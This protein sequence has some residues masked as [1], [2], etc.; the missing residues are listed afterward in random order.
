MIEEET[1]FDPLVDQEGKPVLDEDGAQKTR[2]RVVR[3]F[4]PTGQ[5]AVPQGGDV[6]STGWM[7]TMTKFLG[8]KMMVQAVNPMGMG[9]IG[10][11]NVATKQVVLRDE[12]GKI[13]YDQMKQPI[14]LTETTPVAPQTS[15][16]D[17]VDFAERQ[18][19]SVIRLAE[20]FKGG[21][22]GSLSADKLVERF[23]DQLDR[24]NQ[25]YLKRLEGDIEGYQQYDPI[26]NLGKTLEGLEKIGLD[27][28][29]QPQTENIEIAKMNNNLEMYRIDKHDEW[30]RWKVEQ[31]QKE[32][33]R[34]FGVGQ[35]DRVTEVIST[36]IDKIGGPLANGFKDGLVIG[37]K[38]RVEAA[39][40]RPAADPQ[41]Q[42]TG[43]MDAERIR[44]MSNE[45][46]L[47]YLQ[48]VNNADGVVNATRKLVVAEIGIRG[49]QV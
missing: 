19:E 23:L 3:R 42:P 41:Q 4:V 1:F 26:A 36:A 33:D 29:S 14:V 17:P 11:S 49:L 15:Q 39:A 32:R 2:R 47:S 9:G 35:M 37:A 28:S 45:E 18:T 21:N 5:R 20:V 7:D 25:A 43:P 13:V 16:F 27:F 38:S 6:G 48:H 31:A 24:S 44:A 12:E 30:E 10:M 22:N 8:M 46:L 34:E 40:A